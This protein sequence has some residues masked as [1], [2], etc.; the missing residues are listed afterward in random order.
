MSCDEIRMIDMDTGQLQAEVTDLTMKVYDS[1][2]GKRGLVAEVKASGGSLVEKDVEIIL[3]TGKDK[4]F[5][6]DLASITAPEVNFDD[7][8]SVRTAN[9]GVRANADDASGA[10]I[11]ELLDKQERLLA[12]LMQYGWNGGRCGK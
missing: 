12:K 7:V 5:V 11:F 8:D 9:I 2:Q 1:S 4:N 6:K 10:F 3:L